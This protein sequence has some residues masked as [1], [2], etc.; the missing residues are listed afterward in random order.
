MGWRWMKRNIDNQ[1]C[2]QKNR[3]LH[4]FSQN[5][6]LKS[7]WL[8]LLNLEIA[9]EIWIEYIT[10][11]KTICFS[12]STDICFMLNNQMASEFLDSFWRIFHRKESKQTCKIMEFY[13]FFD[14]AKIHLILRLYRAFWG[15]NKVV[16][17]KGIQG[18][19]TRYDILW[20]PRWPTKNDFQVQKKVAAH[21][22]DGD[23]W[24]LSTFFQKSNIGWPQQPPTE[25]V[26]I[27]N[28]IFYDSTNIFFI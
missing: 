1:Y 14:E 15:S 2:D 16:S 13:I 28:L 11:P 4:N 21:S 27:F 10:I 7:S 25:M 24:V 18:V 22:G 9:K 5:V 3:W 6:N 19:S 17:L 8:P 26:P 23:I 12:D 20:C